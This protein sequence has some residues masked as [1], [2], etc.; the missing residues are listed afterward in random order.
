MED[1]K[2]TYRKV[3]FL[4]TN[5][6]HQEK[7]R[8]CATALKS[9]KSLRINLTKEVKDLYSKNS[10]TMMKES[11]G[12]TN[13]WITS[14]SW[15]SRIIIVKMSIIPKG[16]HIFNAIP[17]KTSMSFFHGIRQQII[18]NFVGNHQRLCSFPRSLK[19]QSFSNFPKEKYPYEEGGK[20]CALRSLIPLM[21]KLKA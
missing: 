6:N 13:K 4:Y 18:L 8:K 9:I 20:L 15:I 11:E 17:I 7:L 12:D 10:R 14:C 3:L 19:Q 1:I 2:S 21:Y 5:N 16:V